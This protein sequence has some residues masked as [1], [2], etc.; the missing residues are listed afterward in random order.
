MKKFYVILLLVAICFELFSQENWKLKKDSQG[1]QVFTQNTE[2]T[3][4][5]TFKATTN[6]KLT[7]K[8][9]LEILQDADNYPLW[10]NQISSAKLIQSNSNAFVVYYIVKMPIGFKNRDI[11]LQNTIKICNQDKLL[12]ELITINDVVNEKKDFVRITDGKGFWLVEKLD[13]SQ[14]R[15]T[16]QFY[17]DPKGDF[18]SWLVNLFL[19]DGPFETL[20]NL[21][22]KK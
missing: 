10:I 9:I 18:P 5:C 16:Y 21:K 1:I 8:R 3:G 19:V 4:I 17:S 11:V 7:T 15:V 13:N 22:Q 12:V 2:N 14:S 20:L 6:V